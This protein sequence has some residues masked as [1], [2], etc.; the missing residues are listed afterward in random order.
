MVS[1]CMGEV[2]LDSTN[3]NLKMVEDGC[4]WVYTYGNKDLEEYVKAEKAARESKIGLWQN[5]NP[6]NPY[7][8]RKMKKNRK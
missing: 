2:F 3:I 8:W 5:P 1:I 7:Q 6:I 4:A